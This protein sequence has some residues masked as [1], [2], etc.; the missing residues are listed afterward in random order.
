MDSIGSH[1]KLYPLVSSST[2]VWSTWYFQRSELN[3]QKDSY[4]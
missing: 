4:S 1:D 2:L 3:E